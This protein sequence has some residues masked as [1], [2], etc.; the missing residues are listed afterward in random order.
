[1]H[2]LNKIIN[3]DKNFV[4]VPSRKEVKNLKKIENTMGIQ[5]LKTNITEYYLIQ[6]ITPLSSWFFN[7]FVC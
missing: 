6:K 4:Y 3:G 7:S 1:M 5:I 2:G